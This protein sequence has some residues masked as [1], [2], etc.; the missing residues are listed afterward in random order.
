MARDLTCLAAAPT[1]GDHEKHTF[2]LV[3]N[4]VIYHHGELSI[5]YF[6]LLFQ[7]IEVIYHHAGLSN[8]YFLLLF[9]VIHNA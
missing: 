6:L 4:G 8:K 5:K 2:C 7:I 3:T 1:P 9:Q